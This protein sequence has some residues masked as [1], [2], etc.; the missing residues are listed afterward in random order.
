MTN[1]DNKKE[2]K[3]L[4]KIDRSDTKAVDKHIKSV[5]VDLKKTKTKILLSSYY[6]WYA[7]NPKYQTD[8]LNDFDSYVR[9][10]KNNFDQKNKMVATAYGDKYAI[11]LTKFVRDNLLF[12]KELVKIARD[13]VELCK[14]EGR[15][16]LGFSRLFDDVE[17]QKIE[18]IFKL[19][20]VQTG[21]VLVIQ[22]SGEMRE[23]I[24]NSIDRAPLKPVTKSFFK[25][26]GKSTEKNNALTKEIANPT[27]SKL[28]KKSTPSVA[29]SSEDSTSIAA[30][31]IDKQSS[32]EN[33]VKVKCTQNNVL[34]L[35]D[36]TESIS[37]I[38][39]TIDM[40]TKT[41]EKE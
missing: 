25:K 33:S 24:R 1:T 22:T 9:K 2:I 15:G 27:T 35:D 10:N 5:F 17:M 21:E 13:S 29:I 40:V 39:I 23:E 18:E 37:K 14:I 20:Q 36:I 26:V 38:K 12:S 34:S 41:T 6:Q 28:E 16:K 30:S 8:Q 19:L 3:H 32:T 11:I 31:H 7:Q 4:I